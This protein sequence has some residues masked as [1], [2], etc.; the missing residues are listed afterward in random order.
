MRY[1]GVLIA[2]VFLLSLSCAPNP[3]NP[4]PSRSTP[5][6]SRPASPNGGAS[7]SAP[8]AR[9][10][11][12]LAAAKNEGR[13]V[14]YSALASGPRQALTDAVKDKYGIEM[15]FISGKGSELIVKV[16][17]ERRAGIYAGDIILAGATTQTLFKD[18]GFLEPMDKILVLPEVTD[19]KQ[20]MDGK[21]PFLDRERMMVSYFS[22]AGSSVVINTELVKPDEMKSY[23]DLLSPKWK[24][25]ILMHDPTV[26]GAGNVFFTINLM[27]I[28]GKEFTLQLTQQKPIVMKDPRLALEWVARGKYPILLAPDTSLLGELTKAGAPL[29]HIVPAEGTYSGGG[30]GGLAMV[31]KAP[32]PNA[33]ALVI[34]FVLSQEGQ[35]IMAKAQPDQSR[36]LDVSADFI[37]ADRRLDPKVK[38]IDSDTEQYLIGRMEMVKLAKDIFGPYMQ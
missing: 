6:A 26:S 16:E 37:D 4:A 17:A 21:L 28:M 30:S 24:E 35:T 34:N 15:E 33:A 3:A 12:I 36:R 22:H 10:N 23:R 1:F 20:W 5:A 13:V 32:H 11:K 7:R 31:N 25:K 8:D 2:F 9:F 27:A 14:V 19:P 29:K 38:Y 18:K